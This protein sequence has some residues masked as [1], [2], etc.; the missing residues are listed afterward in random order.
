MGKPICAVGDFEKLATYRRFLADAAKKAEA[1]A[2]A[3]INLAKVAKLMAFYENQMKCKPPEKISQENRSKQIEAEQLLKR[4]KSNL[5]EI[6]KLPEDP[7]GFK[8]YLISTGFQLEILLVSEI[9]AAIG[10]D[11]IGKGTRVEALFDA[12]IPVWLYGKFI[13]GDWI[14]PE[15][16]NAKALLFPKN[17]FLR[18]IALTTRELLDETFLSFNRV[19]MVYS[20]HLPKLINSKLVNHLRVKGKNT[21][22][23]EEL[24]K[25]FQDFRWALHWGG[26]VAEVIQ[27]RVE[28]KNP[29][30]ITL[31]RTKGRETELPRLKREMRN[32]L[33]K[34]SHNLSMLMHG[35]ILTEDNLGQFWANLYTDAGDWELTPTKNLYAHIIEEDPN[36]DKFRHIVE[37]SNTKLNELLYEI[38]LMK[39][40]VYDKDL[41]KA[42]LEDLKELTAKS[43]TV[44]TTETRGTTKGKYTLKDLSDIKTVSDADRKKA[45]GFLGIRE[46]KTSTK[47]NR[48]NARTINPKLIKKL[49][50]LTRH[51]N[52]EYLYDQVENWIETSFTTADD[53]I[54][55]VAIDLVLAAA[56]REDILTDYGEEEE[57]EESD[58]E[59][60]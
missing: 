35:I 25:T 49:K 21:T 42:F 29:P 6:E 14:K 26:P 47:K 52:G 56:A 2:S 1:S 51:P 44:V 32:G 39:C 5:E 30:T 46:K 20:Y 19:V 43:K 50:T 45:Y 15:T 8:D 16:A 18:S 7:D 41:K 3:E 12:S 58:S 54:H 23:Q 10:P 37:L 27:P 24:D 9:I 28:G 33:T 4:V 17:N 38:L 34:L 13:S 60:E 53:R 48:A 40:E 55:G 11:K 22:S 31:E 59:S 57:S 36:L